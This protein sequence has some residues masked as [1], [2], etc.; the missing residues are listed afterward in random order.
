MEFIKL[1]PKL[2]ILHCA[3]GVGKRQVKFEK[4]RRGYIRFSYLILFVFLYFYAPLKHI[5]RMVA[6]TI[7]HN[8]TN[9]KAIS[10]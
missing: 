9:V 4:S 5:S 6:L 10:Y 8:V 2:K 7:L 3:K 1:L